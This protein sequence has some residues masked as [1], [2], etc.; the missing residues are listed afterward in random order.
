M[1]FYEQVYAVVREIPAG[2][3]TSYGRIARMLGRPRAARAVGYALNA[4][5]DKPE[6][7]KEVP[8]WRVINAEGRISTVNRELSASK[9]AT[10]LKEEGVDV[11]D[12]FKIDLNFYLWEG[13]SLHELD[14]IIVEHGNRAD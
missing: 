12:E 7:K 9:Q 2:R 13:L 11:S 14:Q 4:L 8:W 3:V 5:K 1:N 6:A 10:S